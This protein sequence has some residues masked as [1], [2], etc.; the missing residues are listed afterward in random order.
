[1]HPSHVI[2]SISRIKANPKNARTHSNRQIR[3]IVGSI[4]EFGFA[5]PILIDE[6]NVLIAGHGRLKA[7][8]SLGLSTVPAI[9]ITGLS[10]AKKR[11]LMLA[12]NRIAQEAGW[13]LER[14]A[15]ELAELPE[16]LVDDGLEI[17]VTGFEPAEIDR[18]SCRLRVQVTGSGR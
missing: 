18:L 10:D 5:A 11:A 15:E 3:K 16:L 13:D 9:V 7:A 6:H 14:L 17:S 4:R 1:M 2:V 12:D 8:K